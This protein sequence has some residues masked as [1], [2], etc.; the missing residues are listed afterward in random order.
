MEPVEHSDVSDLAALTLAGASEL[1]RSKKLSPVELTEA[2][3]QRVERLNPG[4]NAFITVTAD[5]ALAEA[6]AAEAHIQQGLWLGP[7]HG[8]PI[9][10]K[11]LVETA[12]VRT[13]GGSNLFRNRVPMVDAEVVRRL[14]GAGA[15]LL[16]KLNLHEFA[17]GASS[18]ISAFGPVRNPVNP[19][20]SAGGSSSGSAAAVA[21]R[22]SYAA[23][24]T[25]TGGSIRQ[26]AA[27]C[28]IVGFKPTYGLVSARG[29][30]P[31]SQ[32]LDH[33]GPMARNVTDAALLLQV[34]AG[35]DAEDPASRN[36]AVPDYS[37]A[38]T[39]PTSSLRTGVPR[40][41]FF[42]DSLHPEV[43]ATWDRALALLEKL[44]Q[45]QEQIDLNVDLAANNT[46]GNLLTKAEAFA[47]HGEH[48]TS[49]PEQYQPETLRRIR[50]G[51]EV[52]AATY[53]RALRDLAEAR[54]SIGSVFEKVDILV[55]PTVP[56]PPFKIADLLSDMDTLRNKEQLTLRNTRPFNVLGLPTISVPCGRTSA[57]LPIGLQITGAHG[58]DATVLSL[59]AEYERAADFARG[60]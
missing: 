42:A 41:N 49:T 31:L 58:A 16:G 54:S 1:V 12:G 14:K 19:E 29:V 39:N 6:R 48:I 56:M 60:D 34:L 55:T 15:V 40:A 4:L 59:A 50:A 5:S 18:V 37:A 36:Q 10:L 45:S 52:S 27:F 38:L 22:L 28:G 20:Y 33:V 9:A 11:D 17:Y 44:V 26:P 13:T 43:Q 53:A 32:S 7:L 24:G 3:L 51:A 30:V 57:G 8:I 23:V 21:A 35:Y 2:C 47:Y 25:D 46:L